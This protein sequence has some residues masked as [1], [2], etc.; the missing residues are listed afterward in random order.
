MKV[1]H[2]LDESTRRAL[3]AMA[4][5]PEPARSAS[6]VPPRSTPNRSP[7]Q[8]RSP[9]ASVETLA[10][11]A[12]P[13]VA[14]KSAAAAQRM[15]AAARRR[16]TT[17]PQTA[18]KAPAAIAPLAPAPIAAENPRSAR[19]PKKSSTRGGSAP[20][21]PSSTAQPVRRTADASSRGR[22]PPPAHG[23][24]ASKEEPRDFP[25]NHH[26]LPSWIKRLPSVLQYDPSHFPRAV[27]E[28]SEQ[29][30]EALRSEFRRELR[31]IQHGRLSTEAS[32]DASKQAR[33]LLA[34]LSGKAVSLPRARK[35]PPKLVSTTKPQKPA[36]K[37]TESS[38]TPRL[39]AVRAYEPSPSKYRLP[40]Y[41]TP[42]SGGLPSLGRR[43]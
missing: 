26:L 12:G 11:Q 10:A 35:R 2:T 4:G 9:A 40:A 6:K 37:E 8:P 7:R 38:W 5:N 29:E 36:K 32:A 34:T 21:K 13:A 31:L 25:K 24:T 1:A 23:Q 16:R 15:A 22:K 3:M 27:K 33:F 20:V 42:V 30:R 28:M 18:T 41:G 39:R 17:A 14:S 43:S 19:P